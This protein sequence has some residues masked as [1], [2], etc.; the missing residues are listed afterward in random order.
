VAVIVEN[1]DRITLL[2]PQIL[3]SVGQPLDPSIQCPIIETHFI[4][5]DDFMIGG[6]EKG[7]FEDMFDKQLIIVMFARCIYLF[8][9]HGILL[10]KGLKTELF[11]LLKFDF[12]N[13]SEHADL[14][15]AAVKNS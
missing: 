5:V 14:G 4:P 12:H 9:S 13:H 11:K 1:A 6:K 3:Q 2:H 10:L 7:C 15:R 8:L